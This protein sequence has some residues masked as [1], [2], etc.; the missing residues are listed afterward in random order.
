MYNFIYDTSYHIGMFF[1]L[2]NI[3][4]C[5]R[6]VYVLLTQTDFLSSSFAMRCKA[7]LKSF[8]LLFLSAISYRVK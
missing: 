1:V 8:V 7:L 6:A 5:G 2:I 4:A 3:V